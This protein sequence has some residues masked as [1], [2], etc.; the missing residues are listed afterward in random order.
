[1]DMDAELDILREFVDFTNRQV[2]VYCDACGAFEG[3]KIRIERQ[4][5]RENYPT[6]QETN[7]DGTK[8]IVWTCVEDPTKPD[9]IINRIIRVAEHIESNSEAGTNERY[10]VWGIIVF[11]F[12]YWEEEVRPRIAKVRGVHPNEVQVDALGD[13]RILRK[14]IIHNK[15]NLPANEYAK[16]K[17]ISD[18]VL[19]DAPISLSHDQMHRLFVAVK[20][21]IGAIILEK[22]G[23]LPGA[24]SPE[25][26]K[27]IAIQRVR[28]RNV[29]DK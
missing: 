14:C 5:H 7:A 29:H 12:S 4:V 13:I 21:A 3:T 8:T 11:L 19:P 22:T 6:K 18:L 23:H 25:E 20:N 26:I 15:G 16:L 17:V 9:I 27:D 10:T 2:G 1:M 24:P 28:P